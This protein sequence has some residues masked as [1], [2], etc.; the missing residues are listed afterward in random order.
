VLSDEATDL[1]RLA[2]DTADSFTSWKKEIFKRK[3]V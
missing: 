2:T 3:D 1:F